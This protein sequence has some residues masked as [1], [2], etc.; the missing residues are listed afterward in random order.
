M[1]MKIARWRK[2]EGEG[3]YDYLFIWSC[4]GNMNERAWIRD[5]PSGNIE[6][7]Q[8]KMDV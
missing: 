3:V 4:Y 2:G 7:I 1:K 8:Q 5:G 6:E